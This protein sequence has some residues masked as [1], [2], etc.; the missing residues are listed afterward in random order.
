[1]PIVTASNAR[2]PL[3]SRSELAY[4]SNQPRPH[5][6]GQNSRQQDPE[7]DFNLAS[8]IQTS[9][10][11]GGP[12]TSVP[13]QPSLVGGTPMSNAPSSASNIGLVNSIHPPNPGPAPSPMSNAPQN[14]NNNNLAGSQG[15]GQGQSPGAFT[16][17]G[18]NSANGASGSIGANQSSHGLVYP[19][20]HL[21]P[22]ND[23]FAPKQISLAPPGP[24]NRIKIGRQTNAKTIPNPTNGYFDSKV[25]SRMHA[26]VWSQDG[27]VYIKDVKSSNGTFI[28]GERLSPEAQESDVFELHNEDMVEFGIDIVGDDNKSIIHHKV[29]CKVYLVI[30]MEDALGLRNDFASLYRGGVHGGPLGSG[31][32][33][34]GAEGGLRRAKAG[35]NFDHVLSRLQ[36]EL[37]K[38]KE[39]GS[40]LG[41][42]TSTMHDIHE[43]LG[44]GLPPFQSPPYQHMVPPPP[45]RSDGHDPQSK[46]AAEAATRA[47]AATIAALQSQLNETQAS[48][49]SHV[50][51]IKSLEG[52]LAEHEA[53]KNEVGLIKSQMESAKKE[54]EEISLLSARGQG[55]GPPSLAQ[56]NGN[57]PRQEDKTVDDFDDSASIAS[58]DTVMADEFDTAS[59]LGKTASSRVLVDS[60]R[61]APGQ[62]LAVRREEVEEEEVDEEEE[63]KKNSKRRNE[64]ADLDDGHVG[65]RA[66]PD[67]APGMSESDV[68]INSTLAR[69]ATPS[70]GDAA[71]GVIA[72]KTAEQLA[73]QNAGLSRRLEEL[74]LQLEQALQLSKG[75]QTQHAQVTDTVRMLEDR[76]A[77]LEKE[78]ESKVSHVEGNVVKAME[79]RWEEWRSQIE[80]GWRREKESWESEREVLRGVVRAW[81]EANK[82]LEEEVGKGVEEEAQ[83]SP[84]TSQVSKRDSADGLEQ[85]EKKGGRGGKRRQQPHANPYLRALLYGSSS[86]H[87]FADGEGSGHGPASAS[88]SP[89]GPS[90][91]SPSSPS[92]GS[93]S[94]SRGR[95]R[96]GSSRSSSSSN[97][98][99]SNLNGSSRTGGSGTSRSLADSSDTRPSTSSTGITSPPLSTSSLTGGADES[100]YESKSLGGAGS[101]SSSTTTA[102]TLDSQAGDRGGGREAV[103]KGRSSGG[104]SGE[105]S[106]GFLPSFPLPCTLLPFLLSFL[107]HSVG[108]LTSS[109]S[110]PH[111]TKLKPVPNVQVLSVAASVVVVG[112]TAWFLSNKG[113]LMPTG[114]VA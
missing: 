106:L 105:V 24:H 7:A 55:H 112:V 11:G 36:S 102:T 25:L 85:D 42:L 16:N 98:S 90:S 15:P 3:P 99:S 5:S 88:W 40:E 76:V 70:S 67:L 79:G 82:R 10:T 87:L 56:L 111:F 1:M 41:S 93:P 21:H 28:N 107:F 113:E 2:Y 57:Q 22:L 46:E 81:D 50:E 69:S 61:A 54:M 68:G 17:A 95:A 29:A 32:V 35:V 6:K 43:T 51:K 30:T 59:G 12:L 94:R 71:A 74:S 8:I 66:P 109:S 52:M 72:A 27:K 83:P 64:A 49:A 92:R 9:G 73:Q 53:I 23:T 31:G 13:M 47:H 114:K 33:G 110:L 26:E 101:S 19:A 44:G 20:L 18:Q 58:I 39:V 80:E 78:M 89:T 65:P 97:D 63:E 100:P 38:S 45:P 84:D 60:K 75:L 96:S 34:P 77:S 37:Q 86:A 14:S 104:R 91:S 48:L 108:S 4:S 103:G 62:V